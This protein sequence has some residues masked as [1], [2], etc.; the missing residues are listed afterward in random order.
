MA[1][2]DRNGKITIDEYAANQDIKRLS[3]AVQVLKE[4]RN[5]IQNLQRQAEEL[6]GETAVAVQ[7]KGQEMYRKLTTM[8]DKLEE[9]IAFI[10][11]TVRYYEELDAEIKR[12][13]QAAADAAAAAAA[14]AAT[15]SASGGGGGFSSGGGGGGTS[16]G[17]GRIES[18]GSS[19][20]GKSSSGSSKKTNTSSSSKKSNGLGEFFDGLSDMLD[21]IF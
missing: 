14:A 16:G 4:S 18:S 11:K 20:S 19:S 21:D 7:V 6:R 17:G 13:I 8:I 12:S 9:T 2:R 5:A 3:E 10:R 15:S 1:Y